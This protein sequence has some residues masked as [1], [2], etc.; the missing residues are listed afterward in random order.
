MTLD[1]AQI[2]ER[3]ALLVGSIDPSQERERFDALRRAWSD[4]D[5]DE[6]IRRMASAKTRFLVARMGEPMQTAYP[7]PAIPVSYTVAAT[8]GSMIVPD[9][10]SPARF[11]LLNIGKVRLTYGVEAAADLTNEP[12]LRFEEHDL[13]VPD[14]VHRIP[15]NESILGVKRACAELRTVADLLAASSD[16]VA[17]QDGTLI[18]WGAES[19]HDAVR[20]WAVAE[21][22]SAMRLFR[23]RGIPL[24]SYVSS[25][26]SS[27]VMNA[28]RVAVCDYP[29][30][31]WPVECD[32]CR[33]R[34]ASEGHT[35]ACDILPAVPDRYLFDHIARLGNGERSILFDSASRILDK[36]DDDLRIQFFFVNIGAEI[37]RVEVPRWVGQNRE[38]VDQIHAVIY[39]QAQKGRGY[40][41]VLQEAHELAVLS[42]GDRQLVEEAIERQLAGQGI[43]MMRTGKSGS[44]RG[45]Y[46]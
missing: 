27:D 31:G 33:M 23:D 28:L 5:S 40:P 6:I 7:L 18:L 21:Y 46:V 42:M 19:L 24:A 41:V 12:D 29:S 13:Y 9:R 30:R 10:H 17:M 45:R 35:P 43:V 4:A 44:K 38:M 2:A 34:I 20:D 8:D 15:V 39:D 16:G 32:H 22:V 14:E 25:P 36:Y 11:Y 37:A 26:G 1:L 3:I